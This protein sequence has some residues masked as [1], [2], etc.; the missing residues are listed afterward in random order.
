MIRDRLLAEKQ[1]E[2]RALEG[3]RLAEVTPSRRDFAQ[4]VATQKQGIALVPRLQ[5]RNPVTGRSWP[6]VDLPALARALDDCGAPALAVA[7][8][9]LY[10]GSV[11]DIRAVAQAAEAP[12]LRDDLCL[13]PNQVYQ[14]RLCGA[15]AVVLPAAHLPADRL[16]ELAQISRS[17]HMMAVVEVCSIGELPAALDLAPACIGLCCTGAGGYADL[18]RVRQL[19]AAVPPQRTVVLLSEPSSLESLR[20]LDGCIDAAVVGDVLLDA[21]DPVALMEQF[22]G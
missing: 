3:L 18:D 14:A 9:A 21:P 10:G 13:H 15:D 19:A 7:T 2:I 22:T 17:M 16:A 6:G 5:R 1:A 12:I 20:T 4:F 11:D 8:A